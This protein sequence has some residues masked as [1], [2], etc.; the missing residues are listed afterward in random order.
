MSNCPTMGYYA[1]LIEPALN[2]VLKTSGPVKRM[3]IDTSGRRGN[4]NKPS[5][6]VA[7]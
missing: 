3:E 6:G 4:M 1:A 7:V 2:L 5:R